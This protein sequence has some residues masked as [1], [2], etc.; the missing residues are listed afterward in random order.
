MVRD[1]MLHKGMRPTCVLFLHPRHSK[2]LLRR[3]AMAIRPHRLQTCT[4][5]GSLISNNRSRKN[6]AAPCAIWQ[7]RSI[8]PNRRPPS[9]RTQ[10]T[11][12]HHPHT[13]TSPISRFLTC[14][15]MYCNEQYCCRNSV[16]PSDACFVTKLNDVL[17][18]FWYNTKGQS[19]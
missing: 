8:S 12:G 2:L 1:V 6:C 13:N 5:Y 7:S 9:L 10:A 19:L 3:L 14:N 15:C 11:A 16:R 4:R 18:I 17:W